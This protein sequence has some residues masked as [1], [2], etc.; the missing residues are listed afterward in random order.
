MWRIW[1][2]LLKVV[3]ERMMCMRAVVFNLFFSCGVTNQFNPPCYRLYAI[4][5]RLWNTSSKARDEAHGNG[6]NCFI[7]RRHGRHT[8]YIYNIV[9]TFSSFIWLRSQMYLSN[10]WRLSICQTCKQRNHKCRSCFR[11]QVT[12]QY[13]KHLFLCC[14]FGHLFWD[15]TN[16]CI[17]M[18]HSHD[19]L[20]DYLHSAIIMALQTVKPLYISV[21]RKTK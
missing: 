12:Q 13:S 1:R 18:T 2:L 6:A 14:N 4:D 15:R 17:I 19:Y 3:G 20:H 5:N 8:F 7:T 16:T 9:F 21:K 11:H 10:V